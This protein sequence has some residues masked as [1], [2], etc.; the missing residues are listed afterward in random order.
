MLGNL[1]NNVERRNRHTIIVQN[2]NQFGGI[3]LQFKDQQATH[4]GVSVL[5]NDKNRLV[6]CNKFFHLFIKRKSPQADRINSNALALHGIHCF[7]RRVSGGSEE[8]DPDITSV[9]FLI[10]LWSGNQIFGGVPLDHQS[11]HVALIYRPVLSVFGVFVPRRSPGK[12]GT[13]SWVGSWV[14]SVGGAIALHV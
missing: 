9:G 6:G 12:K 1:L 10:K 5:F 3:Y 4:L 2:R 14:C 13:Q 11:F 8:E 7:F